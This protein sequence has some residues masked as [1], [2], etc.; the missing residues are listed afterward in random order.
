MFFIILKGKLKSKLKG[1]FVTLNKYH[2]KNKTLTQ[3]L[4]NL[5]ELYYKKIRI[6][7]MLKLK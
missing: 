6:E 3:P 4:I 5:V 2:N 1:A 7:S